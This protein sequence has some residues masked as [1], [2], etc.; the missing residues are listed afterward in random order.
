M[1]FLYTDNR[2]S[3]D[4]IEGVLKASFPSRDIISSYSLPDLSDHLWKREDLLIFEVEFDEARKEFGCKI[5]IYKTPE[6]DSQERSLFLAGKLSNSLQ[7]RVLVPFTHPEQ[8]HDPYL[9]I[10][11]ENGR[12]YLADDLDTNFGDGFQVKIQI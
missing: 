2:V 7:S 1:E 12:T 4:V 10:I 9:D 11:F 6:E 8:K 5:S 3:N